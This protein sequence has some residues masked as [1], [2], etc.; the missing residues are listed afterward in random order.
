MSA[1]DLSGKVALVTGSSRGIGW[2][3]ATRL[4]ENGAVVVLNGRQ[5]SEDLDRRRQVLSQKHGAE[6]SAI[7]ADVGDETQVSAMFQTIFKNNGRLDILINNAGILQDSL[8]GMIR[9]DQISQTLATNLVGT[10]NCIQLGSRL[11]RRAG[12]GSIINMAS[13]IGLRGNKGQLVYGA[14]KGA[15]VAAT[16]SAAK[17]LAADGI[18]VNAIAPGYIDTEMIAAVPAEAHRALLEAIPLGRIGAPEDVADVALFLAS[19]MSRYVTG[20]VISVDGGMII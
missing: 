1:L 16:R 13:I 2:A 17:E 20:Q 4:A 19:P 5:M 11:L 14:S 7:A 12:G 3:I 10:L 6:C 15:V 9:R 18:R 8:I